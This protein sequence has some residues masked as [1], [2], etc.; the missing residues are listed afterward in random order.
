MCLL[1]AMQ[2]TQPVSGPAPACRL[3]CNQLPFNSS[4][5]TLAP[6]SRRRPRRSEARVGP[7]RTTGPR[8]PPPST[9]HRRPGLAHHT[10]CG[11]APGTAAA[12]AATAPV[13]AGKASSSWSA[14]VK[15]S[16]TARQGA[17][18]EMKRTVT[19]GPW[20]AGA[21]AP[22]LR[23]SLKSPGSRSSSR[24]SSRPP[25]VAK[26][27]RASPTSRP[28]CRPKRA[29]RWCSSAVGMP[30]RSSTPSSKSKR[31]KGGSTS[32]FSSSPMPGPAK[33]WTGVTHG[34]V[35][36]PDP[37]SRR[38]CQSEPSATGRSSP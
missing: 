6:G 22:P 3:K 5:W 26:G 36:Q 7:R 11:S 2:L 14:R 25:M 9:V 8:E 18:C 37:T 30:L 28:H 1:P 19:R 27:S 12:G 21:R 20:T 33:N 4:S 35:G 17:M 24:G 29:A 38:I 31:M 23:S 10:G 32:S 34:F 16:L 13:A 15:S